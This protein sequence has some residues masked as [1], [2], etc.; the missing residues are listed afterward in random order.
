MNGDAKERFDGPASCSSQDVAGRNRKKR[1][2]GVPPPARGL[3][4][5]NSIFPPGD[6]GTTLWRCS[7]P[8][9]K[10]AGRPYLSNLRNS[11]DCHETFHIPVNR[12]ES[13]SW[14][15]FPWGAPDLPKL[16]SS[17]SGR[18][19][20]RQGPIRCRASISGPLFLNVLPEN[21][22]DPPRCCERRRSDCIR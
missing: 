2:R 13:E 9:S 18:S 1:A 11:L 6:N 14:E 19:G 4:T 8:E 22:D 7:R 5:N 20:P 16:S 15:L 21:S 10:N 12:C 17:T 3:G